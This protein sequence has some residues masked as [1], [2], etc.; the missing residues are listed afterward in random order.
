MNPAERLMENLLLCVQE[1]IA[2]AKALDVERLSETT[3]LRQDLLFELELERKN[4]N[5]SVTDKMKELK[6]EIARLDERLMVI[7]STVKKAC[8]GMKTN[9]PAKVYGANG[10]ILR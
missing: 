5:I 3:E 7:L 9:T 4:N 10:R 2:A 8:E 6:E 1:Q